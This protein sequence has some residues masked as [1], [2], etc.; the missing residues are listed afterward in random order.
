MDFPV[1]SERVLPKGVHIRR[2]RESDELPSFEVMRRA[3]GFD[4]TWDYHAPTRNYIRNAVGCSFW[5]AEERSLLGA[6]KLLGYARALVRDEVMCI[7]ECFVLPNHHGTG[8]GSGLLNHILHA[9]GMAGAKTR[10]VLASQSPAAQ[11]LYIQ[12]AACFPRI[13][14]MMFSAPES[15]VIE[16]TSHI[17]QDL[18]NTSVQ[19]QLSSNAAAS[20]LFTAEAIHLTPE[21]I[22][23]LNQIDQRVVGFARPDEHAFWIHESGGEAGSGRLFRY[24]ETGKIAGYGYIG[25]HFCGPIL[26][27]DPQYQPWM[28]IHVTSLRASLAQEKNGFFAVTKEIYCSVAGINETMLKWLVNSG[29]KLMF[30]YTYMSSKPLGQLDRYIGHEPLYLL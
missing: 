6:A 30:H 17:I 14:M 26:S 8:I 18:S 19:D 4:I 5:V 1:R 7:T 13:P 16:D 27:L 29:W 2:G 3:M 28:L 21:L 15:F 9:A 23:E 24:R 22:E 10:M 25:D 11:R 20:A 12:R